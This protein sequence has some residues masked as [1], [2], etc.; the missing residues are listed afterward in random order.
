VKEAGFNI[1]DAYREH[2]RTLTRFIA[3]MLGDGP[4]VDDVLQETFVTAF[5]KRNEFE[6]RSA[7]RTWLY[8]IALRLCERKRRGLRRFLSFRSK[9]ESA[10]PP[11]APD[12]PDVLVAQQEDRMLVRRVLDQ[13]PFKQREVLVLYEL[14][15]LEGNEIAV[16]VDA[17]VGTVWTRLHLARKKFGEAMRAELGKGV[18]AVAVTK[19][20]AA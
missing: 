7:L 16:L 4:D 11:A 5:K 13:L 1:D 20:E 2:A 12:E 19:G 6:G 10:P 8:A 9:L 14:E 17:P 15:R 18:G 3:R